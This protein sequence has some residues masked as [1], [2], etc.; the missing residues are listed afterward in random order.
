MWLFRSV[1]NVNYWDCNRTE[2]ALAINEGLLFILHL[3]ISSH[4]LLQRHIRLFAL[5][6]C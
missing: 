5:S 6:L 2:D 1:L 4:F 3:D